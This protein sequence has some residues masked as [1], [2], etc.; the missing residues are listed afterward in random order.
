LVGEEKFAAAISDYFQEHKFSNTE[1]S[2]L[3]DAFQKHLGARAD[4]H[5][6][7]N[8]PN[9]QSSWLETAGLNTVQA[10][11]ANGGTSIT[12][13]QGVA[14][15]EH[16]TLRFHRIDVAF[17]NAEGNVIKNQE[18]ILNDQAETIVEIEGGIP[19]GTVAVLPNYNDY[20]FI[21]VIFDEASQAWFEANI[22]KVSEPL[23]IGLILRAMYDGVR[24]AR[25]K[26]SSFIT[27]VSEL[28]TNNDSNQIIDLAFQYISAAVAIIPGDR[29][30]EYAHKLYR[31][32]RAKIVST[33]DS[34]FALSMTEKLVHYCFQDEDIADLKT[35][36]DGEAGDFGENKLSTAQ[37]WSIAYK[38]NGSS[39]FDAATSKAAF[40]LMFEEDQ[41]DSRR[42]YKLKIDALNAS[43]EERAALFK[44]Y[45]NAETKMSYVE[46][47]NSIGGF[48]SRFVDSARKQVYFEEYWTLITE[49]ME[50]RSR[51]VAMTLWRS[52]FP[53]SDDLAYITENLNKLKE[54]WESS[55]TT[56]EYMKKAVNQKIEEH[57][58]LVRARNFELSN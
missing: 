47:R 27:S 50:K 38:I 10:T 6:A 12:L 35:W 3:L 36:F 33:N 31:A 22:S 44:E 56:T 58:R 48:T 17:Y 19:E 52:L 39:A 40:D 5:K 46:L 34:N 18:V 57:A 9:W 16:P 49:A 2:D 30:A 29:Y 21:K 42:N 32:A 51:Q 4:E 20:S 24:D 11:W 54:T 8:I 26:A 37:R 55:E 43:D 1:L 25:Y 13:T 28:I 45:F 14:M 23:A 7:Y 41:T 15:E 53:G